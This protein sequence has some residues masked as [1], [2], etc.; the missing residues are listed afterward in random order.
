MNDEPAISPSLARAG[1]RMGSEL[2]WRR[3]DALAALE[4]FAR[5]RLGVLGGELWSVRGDYVVAGLRDQDD[6][7]ATVGWTSSWRTQD[8][9]WNAFVTRSVA[10][11]RRN[12]M[13]RPESDGVAPVSESAVLYNFTVVS[14]SAY[15]GAA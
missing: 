3:A 5:L 13:S 6:R 2:A 14:E 9:T 8:E 10:E 1:V 7:E 4:E 12:V 15:P 11:A